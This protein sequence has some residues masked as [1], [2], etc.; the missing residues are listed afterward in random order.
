MKLADQHKTIKKEL[1]ENLAHTVKQLQQENALKTDISLSI[2]S[3]S[4]IAQHLVAVI[5]A[6][7]IHGLK[8][9]YYEKRKYP[10][11]LPR[12]QFWNLICKISHKSTLSQTQNLT[13]V[14]TRI[15]Q[16]RAW[17]RLA[18]NDAALPSYLTSL[19]LTA[20]YKSLLNRFYETHALFLDSEQADIFLRYLQGAENLSFNLSS[21]SSVLNSWTRTP[22]EIAGVITPRA[23]KKL[24]QNNNYVLQSS[25]ALKHSSSFQNLRVNLPPSMPNNRRSSFTNSILIPLSTSPTL[26]LGTQVSASLPVMQVYPVDEVLVDNKDLVELRPDAGQAPPLEV[27]GGSEDNI[28]DKVVHRRHVKRKRGHKLSKKKQVDGMSTRSS[29][30]SSIAS[31]PRESRRSSVIS[32]SDS[33]LS[34]SPTDRGPKQ[35]KPRIEFQKD[36]DDDN[37]FA[38]DADSQKQFLAAHE[39]QTHST[40]LRHKNRSSEDQVPLSDDKNPF[41]EE[42]L[43]SSLEMLPPG[44]CGS[45]N[46]PSGNNYT[47]K[48][49]EKAKSN[50][51]THK[52]CNVPIRDHED[53]HAPEPQIL[54]RDSTKPESDRSTLDLNHTSESSDKAD[55]LATSDTLTSD[56]AYTDIYARPTLSSVNTFGD[57]EDED[58]VSDGGCPPFLGLGNSLCGAGWSSDHAGCND[59]TTSPSSAS[60]PSKQTSTPDDKSFSSQQ[61]SRKSLIQREGY[62]QKKGP[63]FWRTRWFILNGLSRT[64]AFFKDKKCDEKLDSIDIRNVMKINDDNIKKHKSISLIM[65]DHS[66]HEIAAESEQLISDWSRDINIVMNDTSPP[67]SRSSSVVDGFEILEDGNAEG[68]LLVEHLNTSWLGTMKSHMIKIAN[69]KGIHAQNYQCADCAAP[70]GMIYGTPRVCSFTGQYYCMSCHKNDQRVIPA[71]IIHNWDFSKHSVAVRS[72]NFLEQFWHDPCIK[73]DLVNPAAYRHL[74]DMGKLLSLRLKL[75]ALQP[76]LSTCRLVNVQQLNGRLKGRRYMLTSP[77]LYSA[78]DLQKAKGGTLSDVISKVVTF[79]TEHVKSCPL[80]SVKG[81]ICEVCGDDQ[82]IFAFETEITAQCDECKSVYHKHCLPDLTKC[83]KCRRRHEWLKREQSDV[84]QDQTDDEE[85]NEEQEET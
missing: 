17:L 31:D 85:K 32:H 6:A 46:S 48:S 66:E 65:K 61:N 72:K 36:E 70:I 47:V 15:G 10:K 62:L 73:M 23:A 29:S 41:I 43:D 84:F 2:Q 57:S 52:N 42:D 79:G 33:P 45:K 58:S 19:F 3:D 18:L 49:E 30:Y 39:T 78:F 11:E 77:H 75:T 25:L 22:L 64:L 28:E 9:S 81:F 34:V 8:S 50:I 55:T 68:Y 71:R 14:V 26:S 38:L 67:L 56:G 35:E 1:N 5:E 13:Q 82:V 24:P 69:E 37:T 4:S 7:F 74:A 76:Y 53:L 80:C 44:A 83:P 16:C 59:D 40:P 51:S 12:P 63:L 60:S 20:E 54:T 27:P 21:N